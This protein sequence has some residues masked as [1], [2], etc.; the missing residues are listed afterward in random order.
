MT[1]LAGDRVGSYEILGLLGAGGMGEVYLARDTRLQRD[2]A[3]KTLPAEFA[4]DSARLARFERE[5]RLLASLNHPNIATIH[6]LEQ[7]GGSILLVLERVEGETLGARL[8]SGPLPIE[9]ALSVCVLIAR[10]LEAAHEA[11]VIHRDLKPGNVMVRPDGSIKVLDFGL[12]RSGAAPAERS[13]DQSHSPTLTAASQQGVILGT[14]A[15]MSPEQ[16]RGRPLDKRTDIFSFGCVLYECLTGRQAFRGETASDTLA[17]ILKLEPDPSALPPETPAPVRAV[18]RRC[19]EKDPARRLHDIADARIELEEALDSPGSTETA[20]A[21]TSRGS[22]IV[23]GAAVLLA[24]VLGFF[25]AWG[26]IQVSRPRPA[27][28]APLRASLTLPP[29]TSLRTGPY[30][31][32]LA[33][34]PDG[35]RLVFRLRDGGAG[36]YVRALDSAETTPIAG[37][38]G[39]IAPFFSPDGEWLAFFTPR[40]LKKVALAGGT[41]LVVCEVSP[42][43]MGG[44]WAPDGWIYFTI[45][46]RGLLRVRSSGGAP[47]PFTTPDREAG[48]RA[49]VWPQMLPGGSQMLVVVRAG[50]DFQDFERSNLA[51]LDVATRKLRVVLEGVS[52]GRFAPPGHLIFARGGSVLAVP[53]DPGTL[54]PSGSHLALPEEIVFGEVSRV[55]YLASAAGVLAYAAGEP[56]STPKSTL[57]WVDRAGREEALPLEPGSYETPILSPDGKTLAIVS[58]QGSRQSIFTYDL[59]RNVLSP[60]LPESGR[61]FNQTWTPDSRRIVFTSFDAGWPRLFWK[62]ADGSGSPEPLSPGE[63]PEFPS[64]V[65]PDGKTLAYAMVSTT[66]EKTDLWL[67]DLGGKRERRV[68]FETPFKEYGAFFSP[69]GGLIAYTAEESGR[70]PEIYVRPYPGPGGRIKISGSGG[71][72]EPLWSPDGSELYFR[73]WEDD[74]MAARIVRSPSLTVSAPRLVLKTQ[75][76]LS[77][78]GEDDPRQYSISPDGK[79]FLFVKPGE[80]KRQTITQIEIVTDWAALFGRQAGEKP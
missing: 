72:H 44:A 26:I 48:E 49:H 56:E 6:V 77:Q 21:R 69:D 74:L 23:W 31:P 78:T 24:G 79:R 50:K 61:S 60:L 52:F 75:G 34:S 40:E 42:V 20:P 64:S 3:I 54:E 66:P 39:G 7:A 12:A 55:P 18:L 59:E 17:A 15:Y 5:A 45:A 10:G 30:Q 67:L 63:S 28:R 19:L 4:N 43:T 70:K 51:V 36:L 37:T 53:C 13:P 2:V 46:N 8:A 22:P 25:L 29:G 62:A 41:P 71:G 27:P 11:G 9:E 80:A 14:A 58:N 1:L 57:V 65:S 33:F 16:A 68:W 35:R 73:T 47:E 32:S 38:E 76:Y